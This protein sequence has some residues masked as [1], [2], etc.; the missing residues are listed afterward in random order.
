MVSL[1]PLEDNGK[2]RRRIFQKSIFVTL[3]L[4]KNFDRFETFGIPCIQYICR[5][6]NI[7]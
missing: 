3:T 4:W 2:R 7:K 1:H 5:F 6:K